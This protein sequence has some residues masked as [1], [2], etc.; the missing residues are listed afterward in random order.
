MD[1]G[2]ENMRRA[3]GIAYDTEFANMVTTA[4]NEEDLV[5][6]YNNWLQSQMAI[7]QPVLDELNNKIR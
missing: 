3:R 1:D 7:I 5:S 4:K 2:T 6:I